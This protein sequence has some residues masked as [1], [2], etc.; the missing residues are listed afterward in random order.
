MTSPKMDHFREYQGFGV[1]RPF[2]PMAR[3]W[4]QY[5]LYTP[6]DIGIHYLRSGGVYA[7]HLPYQLP[8]RY[9]VSPAG[10]YQ[11][12]SPRGYPPKGGIY[13]GVGRYLTHDMLI[14]TAYT[15][16]SPGGPM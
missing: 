5:P 2:R 8:I 14:T 9:Y 15:P 12:I 16:R 13:R 1:F 6:R 3:R 11:C 7:L 10:S 4:A